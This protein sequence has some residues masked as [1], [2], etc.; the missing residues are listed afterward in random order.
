[1]EVD[2]DVFEDFNLGGIRESGMVLNLVDSSEAEIGRGDGF[3]HYGRQLND[4][5]IE[6]PRS[7]FQHL[8]SRSLFVVH[9]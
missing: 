2:A 1:M 4:W 6:S 5:D 8:E 3:L 7:D 9:W